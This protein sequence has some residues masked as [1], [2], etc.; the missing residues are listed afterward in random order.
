MNGPRPGRRVPLLLLLLLLLLMTRGIVVR[1]GLPPFS[2]ARSGGWRLQKAMTR[3]AFTRAC[4]ATTAG[5]RLH[6]ASVSERSRVRPRRHVRRALLMGVMGDGVAGRAS[7]D[8]GFEAGSGIATMATTGET[9]VQVRWQVT[10]P[11]SVSKNEP[12]L[13]NSVGG[14]DGWPHVAHFHQISTDA[15]AVSKGAMISGI[16]PRSRRQGHDTQNAH[17]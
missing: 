1:N 8:G 15:A 11:A 9:A 12:H 5:R 10:D 13:Q 16:S 17:A 6:S 14:N 3:A 7:S 4:E 2:C